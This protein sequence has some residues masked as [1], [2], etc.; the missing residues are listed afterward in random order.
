MHAATV[1]P[2]GVKTNIVHNARF[3]ADPRDPDITH[4][5]A[6]EMFDKLAATTPERAAKIIHAGV[7]AGRSRILVGP[8]ARFFDLLV[9]V[10]PTHYYDV[11][12]G[13]EGLARRF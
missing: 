9:R 10:M 1:H 2:G 13:L 7:R 3:H 11:L 4:A 12:A 5:Q 8:D 6:A